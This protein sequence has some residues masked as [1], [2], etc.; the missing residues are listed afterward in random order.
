MNYK[1]ER[2]KLRQTIER[3]LPPGYTLTK[4]LWPQQVGAKIMHGVFGLSRPPVLVLVRDHKTDR[5][6]HA[7]L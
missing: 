4:L 6:I 5:E 2:E 7:A 3:A 1:L